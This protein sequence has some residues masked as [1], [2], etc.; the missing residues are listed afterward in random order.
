MRLVDRTGAPEAISMPP[1]TRSS[2]LN[3]P[4]ELLD[5]R[6][7]AVV[8]RTDDRTVQLP[9]PE[10]PE[11]STLCWG[12]A[13]CMSGGRTAYLLVNSVNNL[14]A[15]QVIQFTPARRDTD[16][17]PVL[18]AGRVEVISKVGRRIYF[19]TSAWNRF[20]ERRDRTAVADVLRRNEDQ[21]LA[22]VITVGEVLRTADPDRRRLL[23]EAMDALHGSIAPLLDH[24]DH[25]AGYAAETS[26][27][28]EHGVNLRQGP[29]ATL[30]SR[31]L[32]SPAA[33][34]EEERHE[35]E[36][37]IR[38]MDEDQT[39][40]FE[41]LARTGP[42]AGQEFC[43]AEVLS[44]PEFSELFAEKVPVAIERGLTGQQVREL[45]AT[46]DVW[47]A[48]RAMVGFAIDAAI[49]R[50]P[51][52]R[53]SPSGGRDQRRPGGPDIQQAVYLGV[54][55]TFVLRDGWLQESLIKIASAAGLERRILSTDD[56][57]DELLRQAS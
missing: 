27:S 55:D 10:A 39:A 2:S 16:R 19:E 36:N 44:R 38:A 52:T 11:S 42:R 41:D 23:C 1:S 25:L 34:S 56:F 57:F 30:L 5:H 29:G 32:R 3:D 46:S 4:F 31:Y 47:K 24:P 40:L 15:G 49:D 14:R 48:Y 8:L 33:V 28:G 37:W 7:T 43:S 54:C 45:S 13:I 22:S 26:R 12:V 18:Y 50:M 20:A 53:T 21:V 51:A 6:T 9:D 17:G 35:V